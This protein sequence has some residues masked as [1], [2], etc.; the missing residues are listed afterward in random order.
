MAQEEVESSAQVK[1]VLERSPMIS[2]CLCVFVSRRKLK[3]L[4]HGRSSVRECTY[5]RYWATAVLYWAAAVHRH[6]CTYVQYWAA[7][8]LYWAAAVH[9]HKCTYVQYWAA[10]VHR[11]KCI[12]VQY[13]AAAVVHKAAVLLPQLRMLGKKVRSSLAL[14]PDKATRPDNIINKTNFSLGLG[15]PARRLEY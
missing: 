14:K 12:Y 4:V 6:K 3:V 10:A 5:V 15:F 11:D 7:A 8:V 13:W 1:I 2:I 9:R